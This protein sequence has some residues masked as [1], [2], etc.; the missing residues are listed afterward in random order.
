M[1]FYVF[2]F[3]AT[4]IK[5]NAYSRE[6]WM[7]QRYQLIIEHEMRPIFPPPVIIITHLYLALKYICRRCKGKRDYF[8]NGLSQLHYILFHI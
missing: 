6:I 2:L 4:F 5:N 1:L 7:F 3:S 8:D